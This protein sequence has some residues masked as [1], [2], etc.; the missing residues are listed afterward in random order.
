MEHNDVSELFAGLTELSK[1]AFPKRCA[2]CGQLYQN[3]EEYVQL[4]HDVSGQT[5]LKASLDDDQETVILELFRNCVCGSTLLDFFNNRRDVSEGGV[6]RR[7][8]FEK[9]H[10]WLVSHGETSAY[11]RAEILKILK[12]EDSVLLQK[13]AA[14]SQSD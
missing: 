12:G 9:L 8:A 6:K 4:T 5:G 10:E 14:D 2:N 3:V 11:A 1:M 7:E 13:Y